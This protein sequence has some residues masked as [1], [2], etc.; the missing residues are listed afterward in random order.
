MYR[1]FPPNSITQ[2][3]SLHGRKYCPVHDFNRDIVSVYETDEFRMYKFKVLLCQK[4]F[5]HDWTA[6]P[7]T[8]LGE[9]AR[10]RNPRTYLPVLCP[11][12][13][14]HEVCRRGNAC[15]FCHGTFEYFLHPG[16]YRTA[17]CEN[18]PGCSRPV[19]FFAHSEDELRDEMTL[20]AEE[21]YAAFSFD[22]DMPVSI[23]PRQVLRALAARTK[24]RTKNNFAALTDLKGKAK[25]T[26]ESFVAEKSTFLSLD[27]SPASLWNAAL[28][29]WP[30]DFNGLVE[31]LKEIKDARKFQPKT[32]KKSYLDVDAPD[33]TR[34]YSLWN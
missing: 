26:D 11:F 19:C 13:K 7:F 8:H 16:K 18:G 22:A 25:V 15:K 29:A 1:K 30:Y 9:R 12:F 3:S 20:T 33:W 31:L 23:A 27:N 17:V 2:V 4:R 6:C 21:I 14:D 28:N 5:S 32:C 34:E 10:R 24:L